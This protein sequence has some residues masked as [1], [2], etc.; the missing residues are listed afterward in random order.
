MPKDL[1][2]KA[3]NAAHR[4]L[5]AVSFGRIG[6]QLGGAPTLEQPTT[7]RRSGRLHTVLLT[8]PLR[9]GDAFVVVASRGGD[10]SHPAWYLNLVA[11]PRVQVSHGGGARLPMRA[12]VMEAEERAEHWPAVTRSIGVYARYKSRTAREIPLVVLEPEPAGP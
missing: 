9:L 3:M 5:I 10:D 6:W 7:G 4:V 8:S 11:E 1:T 12:R 2:L